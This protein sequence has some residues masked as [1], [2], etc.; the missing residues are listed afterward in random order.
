MKTILHA[1]HVH[2]STSVVYG[3]LTTERGIAGWWSTRVSLDPG[4]GGVIRF[5]FGGDFN[6]HMQQTRLESGRRVEWRCVGGHDNWRDN[7]FVFALEDR[8]GETML[9]FTQEYAQELSDEV[10]GI[11][12]FN[13]GYYLNSLKQL[14]EKGA[15]MPYAPAGTN[16]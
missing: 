8:K 5:T 14:C 10:Y 13:W 4:E 3:A 12:N 16:S 7:T 6:P 9:K 2:A 11:Y 1:V 15:G